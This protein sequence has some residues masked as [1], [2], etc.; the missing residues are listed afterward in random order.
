MMV[1]NQT[2]KDRKDFFAGTDGKLL[3]MTAS[4]KQ[5]T[6]LASIAECF[7]SDNQPYMSCKERVSVATTLAFDFAAEYSVGLNISYICKLNKHAQSSGDHSGLLQAVEYMQD[8]EFIIE[9][10]EGVSP[11]NHHL[12]DEIWMNI[13]CEDVARA[14]ET[15]HLGSVWSGSRD[16]SI[17]L[18]D[19]DAYIGLISLTELLNGRG[20]YKDTV[21]TSEALSEL[22][23]TIKSQ[24]Y[25]HV[26]QPLIQE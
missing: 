9:G 25:K 3:G 4:I 2:F 15:V 1:N 26:N 18:H 8:G 12:N 10:L 19:K 5:V 13:D 17:R 16:L 14:A 7:D 22:R 21:F 20:D 11:Y 23:A 6:L 24:A